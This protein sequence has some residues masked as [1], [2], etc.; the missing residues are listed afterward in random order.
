MKTVSTSPRTVSEYIGHFPPQ[1][2]SVLRKIRSTIRR[3]APGARETIS[4]GIPTFTLDGKYLVYFAGF[5]KHVS[6]YPA[7]MGEPAFQD[8][9]ARYGSGRGTL[10]FALDE[11]VPYGLISR[12]VKHRMKERRAGATRKK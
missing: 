2:R 3:A 12:L 11:A 4:Y 9:L 7:P 1:I 6:V 10:K 5:K 8:A